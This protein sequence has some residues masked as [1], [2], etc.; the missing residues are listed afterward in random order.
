MQYPLEPDHTPSNSVMDDNPSFPHSSPI[1]A[2]KCQS[3][4]QPLQYQS[5]KHPSTTEQYQ[6]EKGRGDQETLTV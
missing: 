4:N 2:S 1:P 5:G 6:I 3:K